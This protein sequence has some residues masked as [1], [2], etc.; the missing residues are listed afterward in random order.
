MSVGDYLKGLKI[1]TWFKG[2][3]VF[4]SIVLSVSL[5]T[6][7]KWL[8]NRQVDLLFGGIWLIST[9]EWKMY[10]TWQRQEGIYMISTKKRTPDAIGILLELAGIILVA[11]SVVDLSG[12]L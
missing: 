3:W 10:K 6:G 9:A 4:S 5:F 11:L 2:T 7:T 1:D 8:T 12:R